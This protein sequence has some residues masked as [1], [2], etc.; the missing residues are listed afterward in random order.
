MTALQQRRTTREMSPGA[1]TEQQ[2]SDILWCADGVNRPP[3]GRTAPSALSVYPVEI[4]V[5]LPEGIYLYDPTRHELKGVA[6]G[7]LRNT[8]GGQDFAVAAP[9]NL[10]FVMDAAKYQ[11]VAAAAKSAAEDQAR[12]A[13]LEA[14]SQA[15]NI[16]LYCAAEKLAAVIRAGVDTSKFTAAAGLRPTQKIIVAQTVGRLR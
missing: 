3:N 15:Q 8:M 13:A 11:N 14:G 16:Y 1:L 7:D 9:L 6:A 2:L 12:W 10:V 5:V 4:Y